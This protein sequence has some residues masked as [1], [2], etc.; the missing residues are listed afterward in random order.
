[1]IFFI[2]LPS[3]FF[4]ITF[5]A[6][7]SKMT[8]NQIGT[9]EMLLG[10]A[11]CGIFFAVTGGQPVM[12]NGGTGPVL[13]FAGV[14]YKLSESMDVPFL[15]F[16]AWC[17][18]WVCFY[19]FLAAFTDLNRVIRYATRFTDEI[20]AFLIAAIFIINALGSPFYPVG[21]FHYFDKHYYE[22]HGHFDHHEEDG[23]EFNYMETALLSLLLCLGTTYVAGWLKDLKYTSYFGAWV[24]SILSD[25]AITLAI[26]TFTLVSRVGFSGIAVEELQVPHTLAPTFVCCTS[27]CH[28]FYPDDCP[29]VEPYGRRSW[30]VDLFDLHGKTYAIF[31]AAGPAILAFI[32]IF[33]DDG[34]TKHV[35]Q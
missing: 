31:V 24:R 15:T 20:F 34:I 11:W 17:G 35:R 4:Q 26:V 16:N 2:H 8:H 1:M 13:A 27:D 14:L 30:M 7:F 19:M 32:L 3:C 22:K 5:G 29:D 18:L 6:M 21:V 10:T 28:S 33:L 23:G 25:F 12:I 9:V